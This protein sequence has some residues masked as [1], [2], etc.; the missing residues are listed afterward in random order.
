MFLCFLR[1]YIC[2]FRMLFFSVSN[3][4]IYFQFLCRSNTS[5]INM[6]SYKNDIF[7]IYYNECNLLNILQNNFR[8]CYNENFLSR[9]LI[10]K[11][12]IRVQIKFYYIIHS[13]IMDFSINHNISILFTQ[14]YIFLRDIHLLNDI[15]SIQYINCIGHILYY[16]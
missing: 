12:N 10:Y 11:N 16:I 14:Q 1:I 3:V 4:F 13:F 5:S 7:H 9:L 6:C 8:I 15:L 2:F